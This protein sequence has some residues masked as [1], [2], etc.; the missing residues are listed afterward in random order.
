MIKGLCYSPLQVDRIWDIKGSYY[1]R[2]KA[3]FY[4]LKVDCMFC[5]ECMEDAMGLLVSVHVWCP[6]GETRK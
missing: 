4:L 1:N 6:N 2:P 5:S 3:I